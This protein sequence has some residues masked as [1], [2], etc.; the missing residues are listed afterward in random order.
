[1]EKHYLFRIEDFEFLPGTIEALRTLQAAYYKLIIITNQSGIA[2]GYYTEKDFQILNKWMLA[3]LAKQDVN[4]DRVYFCPHHPNAKFERY[5]INCKC[6]KPKT[7]LFFR[8][9]KDYDLDLD[10]CFAIGDKIRDLCICESTGTSGFLIGENED[11][12]LIQKA[13]A[14]ELR[15]VQYATDLLHAVHM[16]LH[17]HNRRT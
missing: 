3:E 14:G 8:A 1:M 5:R 12:D 15:N 9:A 2:K 10:S 16:I 6:R 11:E 7:E 17:F 4:I 13:K